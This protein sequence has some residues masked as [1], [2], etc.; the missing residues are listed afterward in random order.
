MSWAIQCRVPIVLQQ[1]KYKTF[2]L[3]SCIWPRS[4]FNNF[5]HMFTICSPCH[6]AV[7][8]L[9][10]LSAVQ[11]IRIR[12][13]AIGK[14][15]VGPVPQTGCWFPKVPATMGWYRHQAEPNAQSWKLLCWAEIHRHQNI[16][17]PTSYWGCYYALLLSSPKSRHTP[18][19]LTWL[20]VSIPSKKFKY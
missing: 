6:S 10:P 13:Q 9:P 3:R 1:K 4:Q 18:T 15:P 20:W 19:L 12:P 7:S 14:V 5:W 8:R 11:S 17:Y 2:K 16:E